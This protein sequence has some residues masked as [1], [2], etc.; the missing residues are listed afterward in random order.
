MNWGFK[1]VI[2]ALLFMGYIVFLVTKCF[3]QDVVL[4]EKHYY[5]EE[6]EYQNQIQKIKNANQSQD[7]LIKYLPTSNE[8]ALKFNNGIQ[9]DFHG[10]VKLFR[11]SDDKMDKIIPL[12]LNESGVQVIPTSQLAKGLWR[13]KVSWTIG[14]TSFFKEEVLV[15]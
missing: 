1:I 2:A 14:D 11:P 6:I 8:V 3:E 12:N 5:K 15:L 9:N 10:K 4:V 13:V 7:L